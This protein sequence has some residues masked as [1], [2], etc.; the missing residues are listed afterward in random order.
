MRQVECVHCHEGMALTDFFTRSIHVSPDYQFLTCEC[1]HCQRPVQAKL[2]Q[3]GIIPCRLGES[4]NQPERFIPVPNLK[5]SVNSDKSGV[6]FESRDDSGV[7]LFRKFV[8]RYHT[9]FK[10]EQVSS[11]AAIPA[12]QTNHS[13]IR[14]RKDMTHVGIMDSDFHTRLFQSNRCPLPGIFLPVQK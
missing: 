5:A 14:Q 12:S 9:N 11:D 8:P 4:F 2:V 1:T 13:N 10:V 6:V 7:C 3:G